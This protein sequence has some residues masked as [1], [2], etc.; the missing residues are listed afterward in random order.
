MKDTLV[1][2]VHSHPD[3]ECPGRKPQGMR[4]IFELLSEQHASRVG[5]KIIGCYM[6]CEAPTTPGIHEGYFIIEAPT[7]EAVS[8]FLSPLQVRV[9][10]VWDIREQMKKM[11]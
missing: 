10:Q 11:M 1:L 3:R 7:V 9:G 8:S 2:A 6:N 5:V 4:N